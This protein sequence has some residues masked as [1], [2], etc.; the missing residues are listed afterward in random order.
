VTGR[1]ERGESGNRMA[2]IVAAHTYEVGS[3][4]VTWGD[5]GPP[6]V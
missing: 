4:P 5:A 6:A 3:P 1:A 2:L